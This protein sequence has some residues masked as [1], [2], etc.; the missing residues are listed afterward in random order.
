MP[1]PIYRMVRLFLISAWFFTCIIGSASANSWSYYLVGDPEKAQEA[2]MVY[3]YFQ[4]KKL[5][6]KCLSKQPVFGS[7]GLSIIF[8]RNDNPFYN[9]DSAYVKILVAETNYGV[10]SSKDEKVLEKFAIDSLSI[11][12]QKGKIESLAFDA[13]L[14]E[15]GVGSFQHFIA[16]YN[17]SSLV[18]NAIHKRDS[19]AYRMALAHNTAE[20]FKL[21]MTDYPGSTYIFEARQKYDKAL[22]VEENKEG[23]AASFA[24]F[25]VKYPQ[26]PYRVQ[27]ESKLF[28]LETG[29]KN[30]INSYYAFINNYPE[31]SF[32]DEAWQKVYSI[33]RSEN[34]E[35][36]IPEF[37]NSFPDYSFKERLV[38]EY[39]LEGIDYFPY[40]QGEQWG[41]INESGEI[42]IEA[43][44]DFVENFA[45]GIAVV[46]KAG[47]MGYITKSGDE[48]VPPFY[49]EAENFHNNLAIVGEDE[50][51]GVIDRNGKMR[52]PLGYSE[53]SDFSEGL[54]AAG[55]GKFIGYINRNGSVVIPF[56]FDAG[57]EF[58]QGTAVCE[59]DELFGI[60]DSAGNEIIPFYYEGIENFSN[61]MARV[62]KNGKVGL[63]GR[64]G[65]II[66]EAVYDEVGNFSN[67]RAIVIKNQKHGYIDGSG[68][69]I[70]PMIYKAGPETNN[71]SSFFEGHAIV[72]TGVLFGLID[73]SGNRMVA[74]SF[75]DIGLSGDKLIP[76]K[77]NKKWG[78]FNLSSGK[79]I[80]RTTYE[81]AFPFSQ[82]YAVVGSKGNMGLIDQTGKLLVPFNYESIVETSPGVYVA[83]LDGKYGIVDF[84]G[85]TL[86]PFEYDSFSV[87]ENNFVKFTGPTY[88][89]W[90]DSA[91]RKIFWKG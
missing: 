21:Y 27:A 38:E 45:E 40:K 78:Y 68:R 16:L 41:F 52:V 51:F 66:L 28:Q 87:H 24:L 89:L 90:F 32:T 34:P 33:Y 49:D 76:V 3:D 54:A 5:Y 14:K 72:R 55:D 62:R 11:H 1:L 2:L 23:S 36:T 59:I 19:I 37:L 35:K 65:E 82:G 4:A 84:A 63:I 15:G 44:Y 60:I 22:F 86:V 58:N 71:K 10:R 88:I 13:A 64:E 7:Y 9:I 69:I 25:I 39:K 53:I 77:K 18:P 67:N 83:N 73:T 43:K 29:G 85:Q 46:S 70:I 8:A 57:G 30:D 74:M 20:A 31:N 42:V 80:I 81:K 6:T 56:R 75:E 91:L 17:M 48:L 26:S 61:G 12:T 79:T 47:K 50:K